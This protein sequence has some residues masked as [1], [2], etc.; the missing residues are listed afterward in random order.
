MNCLVKT[1]ETWKRRQTIA[2]EAVV[3]AFRAQIFKAS[4]S[5]RRAFSTR[6]SCR[7]ISS[8]VMLVECMSGCSGLTKTPEFDDSAD[9]EAVCPVIGCDVTCKAVATD[10][11]SVVLLTFG[12][13]DFSPRGS[14]IWP[15]SVPSMSQAFMPSKRFS[16]NSCLGLSCCW[17]CFSSDLTLLSW[18]R[19][20]VTGCL[21]MDA[22]WRIGGT[23]DT[24]VRTPRLQF[25]KN[26]G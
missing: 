17:P 15:N 1:D 12:P 3:V 14:S 6:S 19:W 23:S 25:E 9:F 4:W 22:V 16:Q 8:S 26:F 5:F 20:T 24:S 7:R 11:K 2:A 21:K 18:L 10:C 13:T